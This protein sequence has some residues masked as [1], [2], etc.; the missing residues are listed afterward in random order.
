M[1]SD[2]GGDWVRVFIEFF[3]IFTE[4]D[5]R[6]QPLGTSTAGVAYLIRSIE[7]EPAVY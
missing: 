2:P 3:E 4:L 6:A 5:W 1:C 7:P